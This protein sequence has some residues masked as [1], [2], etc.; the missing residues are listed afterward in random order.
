M[1]LVFLS[2][3]L[4]ILPC[5]L[6]AE[7]WRIF[8]IIFIC[9]YFVYKSWIQFDQLLLTNFSFSDAEE[10]DQNEIQQH[11]TDEQYTFNTSKKF[12]L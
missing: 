7:N 3:Y 2:F 11:T 6:K 1:T 8:L 4:K 9:P 10:I 5:I 12:V